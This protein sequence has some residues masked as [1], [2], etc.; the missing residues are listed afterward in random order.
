MKTDVKFLKFGMKKQ[1]PVKEKNTL[2]SEIQK[3]KNQREKLQSF[4]IFNFCF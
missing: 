4:T 1:S 2:I 3:N